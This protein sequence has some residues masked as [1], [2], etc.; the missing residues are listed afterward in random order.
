MKKQLLST[1][2]IIGLLFSV[3]AYSAT[4]GWYAGIGLMNSS[5]DHGVS[6][7]ND[8]SLTSGSVEDSDSGLSIYIGNRVSNNLAVEF[9]HVDLGTASFKG[10]S[11]GGIIW[12]PGNVSASVDV[13][14]LQIAALGFAPM[15]NSM[16]FYGK[17]GMFMWDADLSLTNSFIAPGG[18]ASGSEDG[19]DI[20]FGFGLQFNF[21]NN[22]SLRVGYEDY[23]DFDLEIDTSALVLGYNFNF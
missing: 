21:L 5:F 16:E 1:L 11:S 19:N 18:T 22:G 3:T 9:A 7:W 2:S 15:S 13:S 6:D 10:T 14:G 23:G 8:G 17:I 20:F 12:N 4:P